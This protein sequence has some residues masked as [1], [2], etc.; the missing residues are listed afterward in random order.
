MRELQIDIDEDEYSASDDTSIPIPLIFA[1]R[2]MFADPPAYAPSPSSDSDASSSG[3]GASSPSSDTSSSG[4][5]QE[6]HDGS[7]RP[8]TAAG[9]STKKK[10]G[11]P[12]K[13]RSG[14][15]ARDKDAARERKKQKRASMAAGGAGGVGGAGLGGLAGLSGAA[16]LKGEEG[17][18]HVCVT[19]GRTDSPEWRKGPLGPKTLCNVSVPDASSARG[20]MM[21]GV[22]SA[23]GEA[24]LDTT[25]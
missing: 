21:L 20:L 18:M 10:P 2:L 13:D 23:V 7:G 25:K 5:K 16:G 6:T 9:G 15:G 11:R 4:L 3:S 8:D 14:D 1:D 19:C 22:R 17:A 24:K 12:P